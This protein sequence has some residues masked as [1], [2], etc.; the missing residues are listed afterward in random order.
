MLLLCMSICVLCPFMSHVHLR[1]Y[2]LSH[3]API[4]RCSCSAL[5]MP[6]TRMHVAASDRVIMC[7]CVCVRT[8][9]LQDGDERYDVGLAVRAHAKG[10]CVPGF[11]APT[12]DGNSWQYS[13]GM[14]DVLGQYR[15]AHPWIFTALDKQA[16]APDTGKGCLCTHPYTQAHTYILH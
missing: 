9:T 12:A 10:L 5:P 6:P 3:G 8:Y 11:A 1:A 4:S 7:T 14:V 16:S 15:E 2:V 13:Q